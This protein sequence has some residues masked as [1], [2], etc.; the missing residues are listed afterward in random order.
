MK[1]LTS[2]SQLL[3]ALKERVVASESKQGLA[4]LKYLGGV[5]NNNKRK[6]TG[7]STESWGT[8]LVTAREEVSFPA[9]QLRGFV[10]RD[11]YLKC[12]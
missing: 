12:N 9:K 3:R 8:P 11:F 5:V 10:L 1:A 6:I 4:L 2:N 7:P